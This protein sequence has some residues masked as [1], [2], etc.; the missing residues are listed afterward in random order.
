[1]MENQAANQII[2]CENVKKWFGDF[3]ALRGVTTSIAEGRR[4]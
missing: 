3:Q 1:M 2:V 4:W